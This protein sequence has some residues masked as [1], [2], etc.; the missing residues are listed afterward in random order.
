MKKA[1]LLLLVILTYSLVGCTTAE[2]VK[3]LALSRP[4]PSDYRKNLQHYKIGSPYSIDGKWYY[5]ERNE[6]YKEVGMASW[7]GDDFHRAKTANGEVF[8][9]NKLTAAHRTLPL[10]SIVK[11]TN[12]ENGKTLLVRVNDRGPFAKNRIIDLSEKAAKILDFHGQ[13]TTRVKVEYDK[14]AT[15]RLFYQ[16]GNQWA[17]RK[18]QLK[19]AAAEEKADD[20]PLPPVVNKTYARNFVQTGAYSS[21]DS[22]NRIATSLRKIS[23]TR[24]ETVSMSDRLLYR[25]KLGPFASANDAD[26]AV[27]KVSELGFNDAVIIAD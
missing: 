23:N 14:Q 25:V 27:R 24:V 8:D 7:Y 6:R 1:T 17:E 26:K 11:V 13:G 2:L 15:A 10:P 19:I 5:P 22:A 18:T 16:P 21:L 12:L 3:T 20:E 4:E 9:K